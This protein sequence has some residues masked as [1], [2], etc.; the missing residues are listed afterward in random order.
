MRPAGGFSKGKRNRN[1]VNNLY[2][3]DKGDIMKQ[4]FL[5][6]LLILA[7][8]SMAIGQ[9]ITNP[10]SAKI[11]KLFDDYF[12]EYI[13]LNPEE[14]SMLGLPKEWGY[15]YDRAGFNDVSDAGIKANYDLSRKYLDELKK[16]DPA[17]ITNSQK[18]DVQMLVWYLETLLEGEK[19][20][21]HRYYIDHLSG[22][23]SQ[24]TNVLTEYH[25]IGDLEDANDYLSRLGNI[26]TR[27]NQTKERIDIQEKKGIRPPI[28]IIDRTIASMEDFKRP[29]P[30]ENVLY[31]DFKNKLTG[32]KDLDSVTSE[33][34]CQQAES[35]IKEKIYPAY[36]EF[37]NRLKLSAPEAD[38][39]P[40]VWKLPDGDIYYQYC[41]KFNVTS[42]LT[43]EQVYQLGQK[44]VKLLQDKGKVLLDSLGIKGDKTYGGL[45]NKYW[46][47]WESPDLKDK[48]YYPDVP[49]R[50]EMILKDY[51]FLI[52]TTML[53]LPQVFS[54][55]PKAKVIVQPVP[56]YKEQGG[57]TYY[58]PASLDGK[59][60]GTFYINLMYPP[61]KPGMRSLTYHETIPGH[62]YQI[63]VQ[64]ELSQKRM[65]KNLL[66]L[67]GFVEGWAMY[68]QNLAY[69][70]GW[71]PDIYSRI[72]ELNSQ[73]FR[74][75][76]IVV[77]AGIHY[78]KWSREQALKYM[79]DNLGW[80]SETEIDRYIV[81]P[82]QACSYTI[83][84]LKIMELR[85]RAK[86]ELGPKFDLKDFHMTVLEN[87]SLPLELLEEK[88][89]DY[90]TQNK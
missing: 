38:S 85:E 35:T 78:K 73:L 32:L 80:S 55:I 13:K 23:H 11:E 33:R 81:W 41:L 42:S 21:D 86:K 69:E 51:Q 45:M 29:E 63:A 5:V 82:G 87:G 10:D 88:V 72:A 58:E 27:L 20:I 14:A 39:L 50:R 54:Y 71:L 16:I 12:R 9:E 28:F 70:L 37:I 90:I 66:F 24:V 61:N 30:K 43:P 74:A 26:P 68:V 22:A 3:S 34:L 19:F 53:R 62:H 79:E 89:D 59:R 15:S 48:F 18:V 31:I 1:L 84:K 67:T 7:G 75:V 76:R 17:K 44:E 36:E 56:E 49:E 46:Q 6:S 47:T 77:D 83:G 8:V 60:K 65:F 52:D 4:I 57:L 40:G 25:T 2:R 64:Q